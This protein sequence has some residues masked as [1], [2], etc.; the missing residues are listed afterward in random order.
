MNQQALYPWV[1]WSGTAVLRGRFPPAGPSSPPSCVS[2]P[3]AVS[4]HVYPKLSS[5]L[6]TTSSLLPNRLFSQ[7]FEEKTHLGS[8]VNSAAFQAKSELWYS[9]WMSFFFFFFFIFERHRTCSVVVVEAEKHQEVGIW[10][11]ANRLEGEI[12]D[13]ERAR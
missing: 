4:L 13:F 2:C 1:C 6:A 9:S 3:V 10:K 12:R 11:G 7:T 5:C 8:P